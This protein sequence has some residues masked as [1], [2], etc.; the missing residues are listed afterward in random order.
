ML[1]HPISRRNFL[2]VLPLGLL[3]VSGHATNEIKKQPE[4][5]NQSNAE[6]LTNKALAQKTNKKTKAPLV[7]HVMHCV[8][9]TLSSSLPAIG[10]EFY[11][12]KVLIANNFVKHA[13]DPHSSEDALRY[14]NADAYCRP[15][16]G[17]IIQLGALLARYPANFLAA[18]FTDS[19]QMQSRFASMLSYYTIIGEVKYLRNPILSELRDVVKAELNKYPDEYRNDPRNIPL[20]ILVK[21]LCERKKD[22]EKANEGIEKIST[23]ELNL[24]RS[25]IDLLIFGLSFA[26]GLKLNASS[27]KALGG[28]VGSAYILRDVIA[29][30]LKKGINPDD[31]GKLRDRTRAEM[32]TW[33]TLFTFNAILQN[34][35]HAYMPKLFPGDKLAQE[36]LVEMIGNLSQAGIYCVGKTAA[37]SRLEMASELGNQDVWKIIDWY[38]FN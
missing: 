29:G 1:V 17:L 23:K 18:S 26:L 10:A 14:D 35:V 25:A 6:E 15:W 37:Q 4:Q 33:P 7:N 19:V 21:N 32:I 22:L 16:A 9:P 12:A 11:E 2:K 30:E 13:E 24:K 31:L 36:H 8:N 27:G 5:K 28:I 34:M 20:T 38:I 3:T